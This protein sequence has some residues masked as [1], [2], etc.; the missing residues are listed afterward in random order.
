M[1]QFASPLRHK[2]SPTTAGRVH[3]SLKRRGGNYRNGIFVEL[4]APTLRRS[5]RCLISTP[6]LSQGRDGISDR[7]IRKVGGI[8]VT[9][10]C[11][12]FR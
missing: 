8:S 12:R 5:T 7:F 10:Q 3:H 11:L 6:D 1:P 9:S 4:G 2:P